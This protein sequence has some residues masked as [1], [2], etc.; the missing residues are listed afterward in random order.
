MKARRLISLALAAALAASTAL[1]AWGEAPSAAAVPA[2]EAALAETLPEAADSLPAAVVPADED[3]GT[4]ELPQA[5]ASGDSAPVSGDSAPASGDSAPVSGDSA[6]A[7]GD[8]ASEGVS[9]PAAPL[10]GTGDAAQGPA[11]EGEASDPARQMD[12]AQ[13][14]AFVQRLYR[15]CLGREADESGLAAWV[16]WLM[17]GSQTGAQAAY[18]FFASKEY[19]A[20]GRT[21]EEYVAD[22]YR[23]MFDREGDAAGIQTWLSSLENGLSRDYV[24]AGFVGG[25]EF[26]N[27]CGRF[28]ITLGSY[29]STQPRDQ[30]PQVTAFVNR[31]YNVVMGRN[32]DEGGLNDW[33]GRLNSGTNTA[34]QVVYGFFFGTEYGRKNATEEQYL[35]DLYEA[36]FDRTGD[37]SGISTWMGVFATGASRLAV[38]DGFAGSTEFQ[39]LCARYG[40]T[41]G[42]VEARETRD[43]YPGP[44]TFMYRMLK[45][46]FAAAPG[47]ELNSYVQRLA[48]GAGGDDIAKEVLSS[49]A[50]LAMGYQSY[51]L[52]AVLYAAL[53][54][55]APTQ[56]ETGQMLVA[57]VEGQTAADAAQLILKTSEFAAYCAALSVKVQDS[58][59]TDQ[60]ILGID[61]S[62]YQNQHQLSQYGTSV[63]D[64]NAV[65][66]SG[67]EFVMVRAV[68]T[69]NQNQ[70][71]VDEYFYQNVRG[72]KAA[73]L[74]VGA[75]LFTYA[76]NEQEVIN[77][78]TAFLN[79]V[80]VLEAEGIRFD[81]P[82]AV[83]MEKNLNNLSRERLSQLT[84]MALAL[85]DQNGYYPMLY[86][87]DYFYR[88]NLIASYF[89]GYDKWIAHYGAPVVSVPAGQYQIWQYTSSGTVPGIAGNVDMNECYVDYAVKIPTTT[90]S[91]GQ[92]YNHW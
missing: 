76:T 69:N 72:A 83:D 36:M 70:I 57:L 85:L 64:W 21:D 2:E 26:K 74:K 67:V 63:L 10:D 84:Q 18:G 42:R 24:F 37:A 23:A 25:T 30:N 8:G 38:L 22:L 11:A 91:R 81:Y 15:I 27:L 78:V 54:N 34:A 16:G 71:Y 28:G 88:D 45:T 33:T 9:L 12:T 47:D 59:A 19:K 43:L 50:F 86:T 40:V 4:Q 56:Q 55:R 65:K 53:L 61:V 32:G 79:A 35:A 52:P 60:P 80:A 46:L 13:V 68:S 17:D 5:P 82:L 49:A 31:L 92:I 44:A 48:D 58:D 7:S 3:S 51:E 20:M 14:E 75:Y 66:A 90:N 62:Q 41:P 89:D 29:A 87:G 73:G 77:E 1:P 6:P 39:N